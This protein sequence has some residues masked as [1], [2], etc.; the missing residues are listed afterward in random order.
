M[1]PLSLFLF[2]WAI[3]LGLYAIPLVDFAGS[4]LKAWAAIYASILSFSAGALIVARRMGAGVAGGSIHEIDATRLRIATATCVGLASI[5]FLAYLRAIDAVAGWTV[6]FSDPSTAREVE[7]QSATFA[8]NYGTWKLLTYLGQPAFLL[9]TIGLRAG[10]FRG[11]WLWA[12]PLGGLSIVPYLFTTSRVLLLTAVIWALFFHLTWK[13]LAQPRRVAATLVA[14]S[15]LGAA[16]F[17]ALGART[18]K[19]IDSYPEVAEQVTVPALNVLAIPYTYAAGAIPVFSQFIDDPNLPHSYGAATLAPAIKVASRAGVGGTPPDQVKAYY[20]IPFEVFNTSPW[21]AEFYL[22]YRL[23]GVVLMSALFGWALMGLADWVRRRPSLLGTWVLSLLLIGVAVTPFTN[24]FSIPLTWE[25]AVVGLV[26]CPFATKD[27][28]DSVA[29]MAAPFRGDRRRVL[30]ATGAALA[31]VA[32]VTFIASVG[33][34][35]PAPDPSRA[36]VIAQRMS[37]ASRAVR[38]QFSHGGYPF[39]ATL[40]SQLHQRDPGVKFIPVASSGVVP[41]EA[42]AITVLTTATTVSLRA[43]TSDGRLLELK[44]I[45]RGRDKGT[46]G[47]SVLEPGS[48]LRNAGFSLPLASDWYIEAAPNARIERDPRVGLS[49]GGSLRLVGTRRTA[50]RPSIAIQQTVPRYRGRGTSYALQGV[51]RTR[52]LSRAVAMELKLTYGDGTHT[53]APATTRV[54]FRGKRS[55]IP[56]GSSSTW[57][58]LQAVALARKRVASVE[59]F[60]V[61]TGPKRLSGTVWVD[62]LRIEVRQRR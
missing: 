23:P 60:A 17:V 59:V 50:K 54:A 37:A 62:D 13:P 42:G 28:R 58:P 61:D 31:A 19:T 5:G 47:P 38:N 8:T 36:D 2:V 56:P 52:K 40:A 53:F 48:N 7:T 11:R 21:I 44:Q 30:V 33:T 4:S 16:A 39:A 9:W 35:P 46:Y 41:S 6:V 45:A 24:R 1:D 3:A 15:V 55:G 29:G 22:D 34:S 10:A 20:P 25:L 26:I 27:L 32:I 51:A 49:P 14:A 57:I 12:A 18:G 43:K